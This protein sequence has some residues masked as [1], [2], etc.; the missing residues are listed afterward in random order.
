M[1]LR[2]HVDQMVQR[3]QQKN[4]GLIGIDNTAKLPKTHHQL[5]LSVRKV[6]TMVE[7]DTLLKEAEKSCAVIFFTSPTCAPCKK[8]YPVYDELA[9]QLAHKAILI[10]V[11][12]SCAYD[13][14]AKY[15]ISLLS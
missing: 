11:D 4:G 5:A 10:L 15:S 8:L 6:I 1:V 3:Q 12:V 2:P 7:L 13:I 14:G 9:V